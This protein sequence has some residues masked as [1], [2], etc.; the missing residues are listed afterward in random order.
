MTLS[1][2][3]EIKGN[4]THF[5][6]QIHHCLFALL[7]PEV[8]YPYWREVNKKGFDTE[9][10]KGRKK[11]HTIRTDSKNRWEAGKNIHFVINNR[12]P[13]RFQF[14][15]VVICKSVQ[16]IAIYQNIDS[17]GFQI[18]NP[19]VH[20]DNRNLTPVEIENLA[21]NDGFDSAEDFFAYFNKDS[22]GKIIHWT[23]LKY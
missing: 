11:K 4:P 6:E 17:A 23:N 1:F 3:T 21:I 13:Q 16:L 5:V 8:Q 15:P 22:T 12:T 14:A 9:K 2:K 10:A 7:E 20:I 19:S 18:A